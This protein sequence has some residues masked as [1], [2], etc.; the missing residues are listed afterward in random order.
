MTRT[1]AIRW[2]VGTLLMAVIWRLH[3]TSANVIALFLIAIFGLPH[4]AADAL[5]MK[6]CW[7]R[8][9]AWAMAMLAYGLIAILCAFLFFRFP[10]PGLVIFIVISMWHF[11]AQDSHG[12]PRWS[13]FGAG[14]LFIFGPF[15]YW[16]T[17]I[18]EYLLALGLQ[19]IN[20]NF[21][22]SAAPVLFVCCVVLV[23]LA[24][25][26]KVRE[27][28]APLVGLLLTTPVAL[29]LPPL[30]SFGLYFSLLHA[31][32]H[33]VELTRQLPGW[34]RHPAVV[35]ALILTW[36]AGGAWILYGGSSIVS[37]RAVIAFVIGMAALTV[38]HM[39]LNVWVTQPA[40]DNASMLKK[41][42]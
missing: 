23:W 37:Q 18:N 25:M 4:G 36:G 2:I 5:L 9:G 11:G 10:A 35:F 32:R 33:S 8:F 42:K 12:L 16:S 27:N 6:K 24:A 38:P 21:L 14:G 28:K 26:L 39:L 31:P 19:Q 41:Y 3:S 1:E 30:L 20:R 15:F 13:V 22:L 7:P 40:D 29:L 34:W 17:Q